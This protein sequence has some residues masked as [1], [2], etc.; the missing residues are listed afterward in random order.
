MKRENALCPTC[1]REMPIG[2]DL[3]TI[4]NRNVPIGDRMLEVLVALELDDYHKA[5]LA[6][7]TAA[8][9]MTVKNNRNSSDKAVVA[10]LGRGM[11]E[12][13]P[14][15]PVGQIRCYYRLTDAGRAELEASR[16]RL[17]HLR[18]ALK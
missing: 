16:H 1:H 13:S 14:R 11:I 8:E 9:G 10:L 3:G 2:L 7:I 6:E 17:A 12:V 18:P 15:E 4:K 5:A